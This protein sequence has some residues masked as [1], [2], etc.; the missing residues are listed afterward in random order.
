MNTEQGS[1][2]RINNEFPYGAHRKTPAGIFALLG[3]IHSTIM[4]MDNV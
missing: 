4:L 1:G 2:K 3:K